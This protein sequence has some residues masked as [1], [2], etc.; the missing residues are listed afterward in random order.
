MGSTGGVAPRMSGQQVD[1]SLG[2][3]MDGGAAKQWS[4]RRWWKSL[5]NPVRVATWWWLG[6][7]GVSIA[8]IVGAGTH[9]G[10]GLKLYDNQSSTVI[11][12]PAVW[13]I[14]A[15]VLSATIVGVLAY[16]YRKR[17]RG[18]DRQGLWSILSGPTGRPVLFAWLGTIPISIV[19]IWIIAGYV[20]DGMPVRG[21]FGWEVVGVPVDRL[22]LG[23]GAIAT[24]IAAL[25]YHVQRRND[26][27]KRL[28]LQEGMHREEQFRLWSE[29]LTDRT[30]GPATWRVLEDL[31]MRDAHLRNS[32]LRVAQH[33]IDQYAYEVCVKT[34][35]LKGRPSW[36]RKLP[37]EADPCGRHPMQTRMGLD[38][39]ICLAE[40]LRDPMAIG[41][42]DPGRPIEVG[43]DGVEILRELDL[44]SLPGASFPKLD[45]SALRPGPARSLTFVV[46]PGATDG[47]STGPLESLVLPRVVPE[48]AEVSCETQ[49]A[50]IDWGPTRDGDRIEVGGK[51]RLCVGRAGSGPSGDECVLRRWTLTGTLELTVRDG[52]RVRFQDCSFGG[53]S[54]IVLQS[55]HLHNVNIVSKRG[56]P[57]AKLNASDATPRGSVRIL[58]ELKMTKSTF[59]LGNDSRAPILSEDNVPFVEVSDGSE[60]T[61]VLGED[62]TVPGVML[63]LRSSATFATT[64]N[65]SFKSIDSREEVSMLGPLGSIGGSSRPSINIEASGR[66]DDAD[67]GNGVEV[68][69][70]QIAAANS[71][72]NLKFSESTRYSLDVNTAGI[73]RLRGRVNVSTEGNVRRVSVVASAEE[74][75]RVVAVDETLLE[76][77]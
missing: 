4:L 41:V 29:S 28:R 23:V 9:S 44:G 71:Q 74:R 22:A 56:H 43:R 52:A 69:F 17:P 24:A 19:V 72:V 47:D 27:A 70:M 65:V 32:I 46:V 63:G 54:T 66:P 35:C 12:I 15:V 33:S 48:G 26:E 5:S 68:T 1:D 37:G 51:V 20:P 10:T 25:V 50:G 14:L 75:S 67:N 6:T 60:L 40:V 8:I 76:E 42:S 31:G 64:G 45:L 49:G 57:S 53:G 3:P 61:L 55:T 77:G 59:D 34:E 2:A 11:G 58:G 73:E 62:R 39:A 18:V 38:P 7:L 13:L 30:E 16:L 21:N 36:V